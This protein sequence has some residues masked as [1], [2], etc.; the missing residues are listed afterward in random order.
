[1]DKVGRFFLRRSVVTVYT[2]FMC[3]KKLFFFV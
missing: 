1:M 3:T 2:F